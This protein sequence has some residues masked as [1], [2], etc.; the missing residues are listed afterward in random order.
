MLTG[1][2]VIT[3]FSDTC[4][5][6]QTL[7]RCK[8]QALIDVGLAEGF[9][10]TKNVA[11]RDAYKRIKSL[12]KELQLVKDASKIYDI[13]GGGGPKR[14]QAVAQGLLARGHSS[15]SSARVA[16]VNQSNFHQRIKP[17]APTDRA[18][19][20]LLLTDAVGKIHCDSRGTYG[21]RRVAATLRV[22]SGLI[23][24]H[25]LVARVMQRLQVHGLPKHRSEKRNLIAVRTTS[26]LVNRDFSTTGPNQLWVTDITEHLTREGRV[27]CCVVLDAYSRKAVDWSIDRIA[28]AAFVNSAL[29]I[30]A[31]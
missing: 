27:F 9:D 17:S 12:E 15:R 14:R 29:S 3:V 26:D 24:N 7:H 13:G 8:R 23:V 22:E 16:G 4:V 2:L 25:K 31:Q 6:E 10:S 21:Y 5:H 1:K 28:D 11:M 18:I 19:R 20:R 30:A